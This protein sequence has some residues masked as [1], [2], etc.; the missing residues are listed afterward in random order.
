M[1][2]DGRRTCARARLVRTIEHGG[3]ENSNEPGLLIKVHI[4]RDLWSVGIVGP[5][6]WLRVGHG[7]DVCEEVPQRRTGWNLG[8]GDSEIEK[9]PRAR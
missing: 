6:P 3:D 4:I 9:R 2:M 8:G 5:N 1:R 7:L